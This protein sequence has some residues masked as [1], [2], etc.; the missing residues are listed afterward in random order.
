MMTTV[1]SIKLEFYAEIAERNTRLYADGKSIGEVRETYGSSDQAE[2]QQRLTAADVIPHGKIHTHIC[3][4][5]GKEGECADL[6]CTLIDAECPDCRDQWYAE[7]LG[8]QPLAK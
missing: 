8:E 3:A 7:M 2:L 1:Q 4:E 6:E 5:C